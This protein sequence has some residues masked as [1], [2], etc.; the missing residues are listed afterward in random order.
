LKGSV[1]RSLQGRLV[2]GSLLEDAVHLVRY[3]D[4]LDL[5]HD[6]QTFVL[7]PYDT[8]MRPGR[9]I[10]RKNAWQDI[11]CRT[12]RKTPS[13]N[14]KLIVVFEHSSFQSMGTRLPIA[15]LKP[16]TIILE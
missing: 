4:W 5:G 3:Q 7:G 6:R 14:L 1:H 12:N 2:V 15:T 11:L 16:S 8:R 13:R 9:I 10:E